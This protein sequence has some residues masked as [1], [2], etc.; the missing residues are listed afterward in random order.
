[1]ARHRCR[2]SWSSTR[3]RVSKHHANKFGEAC[4]EVLVIMLGNLTVEEDKPIIF[5]PSRFVNI[6]VER[7]PDPV[8]E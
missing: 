6:L 3:L 8:L 7:N 4:L 2:P 1:M 5:I